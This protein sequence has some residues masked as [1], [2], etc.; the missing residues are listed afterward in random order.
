VVCWVDTVVLEEGTYVFGGTRLHF[1][2]WSVL[3]PHRGYWC[4]L[5]CFEIRAEVQHVNP[6]R[7]Y[8]HTRLYGA[9]TQKS[10]LRTVI[11]SKT[12]NLML[13][14]ADWWRTTFFTLGSQLAWL[15]LPC[16]VQEVS[17]IR[18]R[19]RACPLGH[20]SFIAFSCSTQQWGLGHIRDSQGISF[21]CANI[22]WAAAFWRHINGT[23]SPS[24]RM[25]QGQIMTFSSLEYTKSRWNSTLFR[26]R[27]VKLETSRWRHIVVVIMTLQPFVVPWPLFQF[28]DPI[29]SR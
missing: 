14:Y 25:I 26:N 27:K 19:I 21:P 9:T 8:P 11:A 6:K 20:G 10:S 7:L 2:F 24:V 16:L 17:C 18:H 15:C 4:K 29:H 13:E 22:G 12:E 5:C 1:H 28:L 3:Y 23:V